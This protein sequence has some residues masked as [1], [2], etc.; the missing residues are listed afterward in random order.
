MKRV[1][2]IQYHFLPV[3]HAGTGH[4]RGHARYLPAAGW[5]VTILTGQWDELGP[6]ET[7]HGMTWEPETEHAMPW[8]PPIIRARLPNPNPRWFTGALHRWGFNYLGYIAKRT[9][10]DDFSEWAKPALREAVRQHQHTPFDAIVSYCPPET[11]VMLGSALARRLNLPL[12]VCFGDLYTFMRYEPDSVRRLLVNAMASARRGPKVFFDQVPKAIDHLVEDRLHRRWMR[13]A[14]RCTGVSPYMAKCASDAFHIPAD[15]LVVGFD[16]DEFP[17]EPRMSA[18]VTGNAAMVISHVGSIYPSDL[19]DG[20]QRLDL[21]LD[22]IDLF[23][24]AHPDA[25]GRVDIRFI[26]TRHNGHIDHLIAGRPCAAVCRTIAKVNS[27][28]AHAFVRESDALLAFTLNWGFPGTLSYPGKISEALGAGRPILVVKSDRDW[29]QQMLDDTRGGETADDGPAIAAVLARWYRA[30]QQTGR[31]AAPGRELAVREFGQAALSRRLAVAL[32]AAV[33]EKATRRRRARRGPPSPAPEMLVRITV[34]DEMCSR[35]A[36]HDVWKVTITDASGVE[37]H[38]VELG[39]Q[40]IEHVLLGNDRSFVVR[41]PAQPHAGTWTIVPHVA[42]RGWLPP[43][44]GPIV[45]PAPGGAP[46]V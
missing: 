6:I 21:L 16:D 28:A 45:A 20:A 11:N 37:R 19:Y 34:S 3:N 33:R 10:P 2:L 25:V 41:C 32:D 9:F 18:A 44:S 5:D 14:T 15:V 23:L 31:A 22:G 4:L 24:A 36:R 12:V 39:R 17:P 7:S 42:G 13:S 40:E 1:L 35:D 30:W 38:A 26:G 27:Q 29:V 8:M 46:H 43:I